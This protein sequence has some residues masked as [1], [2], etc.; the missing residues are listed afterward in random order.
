[1]TGAAFDTIRLLVSRLV[2]YDGDTFPFFHSPHS[3][4]LSLSSS[5]QRSPFNPATAL[6]SITLRPRVC[7]EV[8][9]GNIMSLPMCH[10]CERHIHRTTALVRHRREET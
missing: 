9:V 10:R 5:V 7:F 3:L 4:S 1:M 2:L 6:L 8:Q